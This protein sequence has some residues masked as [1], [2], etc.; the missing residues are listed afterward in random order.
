MQV[1]VVYMSQLKKAAGV[2]QE[3]VAIDGSCTV[4]QL[5][6]DSVCPRRP[7][8]C[9]TIRE[10]NGSYRDILLVF[11]GDKQVDIQTPYDLNDGDEVAIMF[12]IAGG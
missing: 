2:A 4:Q 12:P 8:L 10:K 1:D 3:T 5:L 9:E 7:Q 11:V 6:D